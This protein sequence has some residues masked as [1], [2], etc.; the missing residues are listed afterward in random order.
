MI[1]DFLHAQLAL[2]NVQ[3]VQVPQQIAY[4]VLEIELQP[5]LVDAQMVG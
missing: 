1:L 5:Q 4:H 2:L 3:H